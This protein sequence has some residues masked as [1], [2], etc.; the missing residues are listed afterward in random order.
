M[1]VTDAQAHRFEKE[2]DYSTCFSWTA[3][4]GM[5]A[6]AGEAFSTLRWKNA[7]LFEL[8]FRDA[9]GGLVP[10]TGGGALFDEQ[11]AV[12]DAIS[13]LNSM[14]FDEIYHGRT[15]YEQLHRMPVY[16]TTHPPLGKDLIMLGIALFG[17]TGFGW[18]FSGTLFGVLLVP[19]A[20]CFV[21]RLTRR[22]GAAATAV[23]L[24]A[25][26]FMRFS[27]SRLATIDIYGTFLS[28]WA[29]TA[30]CGTASGC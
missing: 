27:Q 5:Y 29:R 10:V 8:A 9:A 7:Q 17:M 15:G 21:R 30:W 16:E 13:Q 11:D 24:M 12:P 25:L 6:D 3:I 1:M 18:R 28:C 2:L 23:V 22:P 4:G 14:Y 20:W 19:L 26:D